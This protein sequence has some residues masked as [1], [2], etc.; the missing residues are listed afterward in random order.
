MLRLFI[1]SS[2]LALPAE[3]ICLTGAYPLAGET[4]LN[5]GGPLYIK[6]HKKKAPYVTPFL[7]FVTRVTSALPAP[8]I[9]ENNIR[10]PDLV[11][12]EQGMAL[13][14]VMA[15]AQTLLCT[16]HDQ[17]RYIQEHRA[18]QTQSLP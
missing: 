15:P 18:Q 14:Q 2:K 9:N 7:K 5:L 1:A 17:L 10:Q 4:R 13:H 3:D 6:R 11:P 16:G 8:A 12:S